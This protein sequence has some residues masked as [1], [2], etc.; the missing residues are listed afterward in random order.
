[1][2]FKSIKEIEKWFEEWKYPS[3]VHKAI[4]FLLQEVQ[5][6][7]NSKEEK[8]MKE[9]SLTFI[10]CESGDWEG[11]YVDGVLFEQGH[12]ITTNDFLELISKYRHFSGVINTYE[13]TDQQMEELGFLLPEKL[14]EIPKNFLKN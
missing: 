12:S 1:M 7:K 11:L 3:E 2:I 8:E 5:K 13:L 9:V 14:N 6:Y 4:E 10:S